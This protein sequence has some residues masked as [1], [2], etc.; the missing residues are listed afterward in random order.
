MRYS[1]FE[2]IVYT[3]VRRTK[4]CTRTHVWLPTFDPI[5]HISHR[6]AAHVQ[7]LANNAPFVRLCWQGRGADS[8]PVAAVALEQ[9]DVTL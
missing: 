4:V 5:V 2:R 8:L 1:T 3:S 7:N 9:V 6:A